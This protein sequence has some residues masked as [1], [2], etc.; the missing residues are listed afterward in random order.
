MTLSEFKKQDD[1]CRENNTPKGKGCDGCPAKDKE[2]CADALR[3]LCGQFLDALYN[4]QT[5]DFNN[6]SETL[7]REY[8]I[9]PF[10]QLGIAEGF[11][12]LEGFRP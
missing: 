8:G 4:H 2:H 12:E 7:D 5:N 1:Y 10:H 6:I 11:I 3:N 9:S